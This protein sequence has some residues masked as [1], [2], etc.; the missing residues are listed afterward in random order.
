MKHGVLLNSARLA[1][2]TAR[3][4]EVNSTSFHWL[5]ALLSLDSNSI[6]ISPTHRP[7][8]YKTNES[9]KLVKHSSS[10]GGSL[11]D[12]FPLWAGERNSQRTLSISQSPGAASTVKRLLHK[13]RCPLKIYPFEAPRP[14]RARYKASEAGF[15][16]CASCI[17][18]H[19]D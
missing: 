14:Q 4:K 3:R 2:K 16:L 15:Y 13:P 7:L 11:G 19:F 18:D 1:Q 9:V 8:S 5:C 12:L 17:L 10:S 6:S